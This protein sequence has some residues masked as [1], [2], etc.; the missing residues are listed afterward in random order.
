MKEDAI[1]Q[2]RATLAETLRAQESEIEVLSAKSAEWS[3]DGAE[4]RPAT[5]EGEPPIT[6]G[7]EVQL[8]LRGS[9]FAVH[10]AGGRARI[11]DLEPAAASVRD[12][13]AP[14][15]EPELADRVEVAKSDLAERLEVGVESIELIDAAT[16]VWRDSSAGCPRQGMS[17]MQ[18]LTPGNR[19][20]LRAKDR[21][22]H[23]HARGDAEPFLCEKPAKDGFIP[24]AA[25]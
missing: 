22:Y 7:Y 4:C 17:Y 25:E 12:R 8:K 16:V 14:G 18:V 3:D 1:R 2:A 11:C 13:R 20:R 24:A 9:T 5:D 23:Y 15:L 19:I 21:T 10:V 6:S